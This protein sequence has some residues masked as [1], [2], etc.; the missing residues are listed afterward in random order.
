MSLMPAALRIITSKA[1]EGTTSAGERIFE[2]V[3]DPRDLLKDKALP[4]V[5]IYTDKGSRKVIGRDNLSGEHSIM[6]SIEMFVAKATLVKIKAEDGKEEDGFEIEYPATDAGL[7]NRLWRLA[8]EVES[9]LTGGAGAWSELWREIVVGIKGVDWD[10]G[11]DSKAGQRFNFLRLQYEV[12]VLADVVRGEDL[13]AGLFWSKFLAAMDAD[14][15]LDDL[16]RDWRAL[17]TTPSLPQWRAAMAALGL[18]MDELKGI[19][20]APMNWH[21]ESPSDE[22]AKLADINIELK[23]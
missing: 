16:S 1:L 7:E 14:Q 6:L 15:D 20:L 11:A 17:L 23:D 2:S 5:V 22:A 4:V 19:G 10:R 13:P 21:V 18:T 12:N 9:V 8:F 3:V